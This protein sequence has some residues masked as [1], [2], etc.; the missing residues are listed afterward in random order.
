MI[1]DLLSIIATGVGLSPEYLGVGGSGQARATAITKS[2]PAARK[3]EDRQTMLECY[4]REIADW[5]LKKEPGLPT[6]QFSKC[7]RNWS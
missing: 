3:F 5:W 6:F 4:I 7:F 1:V 2:E